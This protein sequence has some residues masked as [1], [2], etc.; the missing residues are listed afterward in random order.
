[1]IKVYLLITPGLILA[2]ARVD[3]TSVL[4]YTSFVVIL[5][6]LVASVFLYS[7]IRH[8][9]DLFKKPA[10]K[11]DTIRVNEFIKTLNS[12]Q[13]ETFLHHLTKKNKD[14]SKTMRSRIL[15]L[16]M[17]VFLTLYGNRGFSETTN[18]TEGIWTE[19][20]IVLR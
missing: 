18:A 17:F 13:I 10:L 6:I 5:V 14:H 19:G 8:T 3:L 4:L 11:Q 7:K 15:S 12:N 16:G 1:M 2:L 9:Q 20:G